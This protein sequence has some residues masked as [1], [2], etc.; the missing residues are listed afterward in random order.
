MA[1]R[2]C[3]FAIRVSSKQNVIFIR[4][5]FI[6]IVHPKPLYVIRIKTCGW[7]CPWRKVVI[8]KILKLAIQLFNVIGYTTYLLFGATHCWLHV[9]LSTPHWI[10][11]LLTKPVIG[12]SHYRLHSLLTFATLF[13]GYISYWLLQLLGHTLYWLHPLSSIYYHVLP[14]WSYLL[15]ELKYSTEY[16]FNKNQTWINT[17]WKLMVIP[18][19]W[20]LQYYS[21]LSTSNNP[22]CRPTPPRSWQLPA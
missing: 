3:D 9:S 5:L 2:W 6:Q 12:Y 17:K 7:I 1:A 20:L 4:H 10:Q 18:S 15:L 19:I 8:Y 16:L 13:I 22:T 11:C 14:P 21:S